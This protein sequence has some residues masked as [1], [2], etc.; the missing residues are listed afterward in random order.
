MNPVISVIVPVYNVECYINKCI[1]SILSQ[2]FSNFELLLIDDGSTDNS[3]KICDAYIHKDKRVC[4]FHKKNEGVSEARN[5]GIRKARGEWMTFIDSDDY[6]GENFFADFGLGKESVDIY[7]QGYTIESNHEIKGVHKFNNLKS[8][9]SLEE[10]FIDAENY[11][12]MN[13]PVC[14]LFKSDIVKSGIFFDENTSYGEDHLFVLNYFC[15]IQTAHVSYGFAYYYSQHEV[16]SLTRRRIPYRQLTYY[17]M[18]AYDIHVALIKKMDNNNF[19]LHR[20]INMRFYNN[21]IRTLK[22]FLSSSVYNINEY[23]EIQIIFS[24]KINIYIG[25]SLYQRII[26]SIIKYLPVSMSYMFFVLTLKNSK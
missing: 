8:Y 16:A 2:T 7:L 10:I 9:Q 22:D 23:K 5:F 19:D 4:V 26:L 6:I 12:I 11:N 15:K 25:L 24:K 14:K 21:V 20:A 1:D 18:S 13:S 3:G 17:A